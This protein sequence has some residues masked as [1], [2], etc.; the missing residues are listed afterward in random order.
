MLVYSHAHSFDSDSNGP[1]LSVYTAYAL[2]EAHNKGSSELE[3]GRLQIWSIPN[4]YLVSIKFSVNCLDNYNYRNEK[5]DEM[6]FE[7]IDTFM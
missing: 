3:F 7:L 6:V 4:S 2:T 1:F 5:S